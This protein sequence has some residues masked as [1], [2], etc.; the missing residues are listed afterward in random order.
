M[1]G[2]SGLSENK[3]ASL[4]LK[5]RLQDYKDRDYDSDDDLRKE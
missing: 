2:V 3:L 1:P 4:L 5:R